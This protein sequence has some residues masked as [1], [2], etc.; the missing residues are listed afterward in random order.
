[1]P[2]NNDKLLA[3]ELSRM[4]LQGEVCNDVD[5]PSALIA[6]MASSVAAWVDNN[7]HLDRVGVIHSSNCLISSAYLPIDIERSR[8]Y[9]N[10]TYANV[11]D[12]IP[13]RPSIN[14][15]SFDYICE[16]QQVL[17][18]T[19]VLIGGP[20]DSAYYHWLFNWLPRVWLFKILCPDLFASKDIKFLVDIRAQHRPYYEMLLLSGVSPE[21]ILFIDVSTSDYLVSDIYLPS[22]PAQTGYCM[23]VLRSMR[24]DMIYRIFAYFRTDRVMHPRRFLISRD[25][26]PGSKRKIANTEELL[27]I[28]SKYDIHTVYLED[29]EFVQQVA[30][31][32]EAQLVIGAHG[33][34][35]GNILFSKRDCK[36]ITVENNRNQVLGLDRM[37]VCLAEELGMQVETVICD[38][39]LR[40]EDESNFQAVHNRDLILDP[41][42]LDTLLLSVL[43][44][45]Q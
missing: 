31:F 44:N 17:D 34:G 39:V 42:L 4:H 40:N 12:W 27:P 35:L 18:G 10:Q 15:D 5:D 7:S 3:N 9:Y 1:M 8:L 20:I 19:Y 26:I 21:R 45:A 22:F 37:F 41:K 30:L 6:S 33:A 23:E 11:T 25:K 36:V 43:D 38:E 32:S 16:N 24:S 14:G 13:I 2:R 28:L 29:L